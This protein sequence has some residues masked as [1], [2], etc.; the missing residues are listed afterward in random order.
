[1]IQMTSTKFQLD[2]PGLTGA[3]NAGG[4]GKIAHFDWSRSL[5]LRRL[6]AEKL[7]PSDTVVRVYDGALEEEYAVPSTTFVVAEVG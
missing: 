4:V 2:H 3:L 6:T 1:M 5:R 7:C